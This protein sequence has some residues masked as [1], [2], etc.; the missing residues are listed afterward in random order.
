MTNGIVRSV[1]IGYL[2]ILNGTKSIIQSLIRN[3]I[4]LIIQKESVIK[5]NKLI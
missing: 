2:I 4:L 5:A 3:G 1:I